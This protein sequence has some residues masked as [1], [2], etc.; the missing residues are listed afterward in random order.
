MSSRCKGTKVT[1]KEIN[2]MVQLYEELG[3][4]KAVGKRMRRSPDTVSRHVREY[5]A[6]H[7]MVVVVRDN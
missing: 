2:R 4:F 5:Y 6:L 7:N 3:T 1:P